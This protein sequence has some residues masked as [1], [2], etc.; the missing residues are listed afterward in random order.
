MKINPINISIT[1]GLIIILSSVSCADD[2]ILENTATNGDPV[3]FAAKVASGAQIETRA[4]NSSY[5]Y[6]ITAGL[7][8]YSG[9]D[10]FMQ[11]LGKDKTGTP[12]SDIGTYWV[13]SGSSG[14]LS[15][16]LGEKSLNWVYR[17]SE[18]YFRGWTLP[19]MQDEYDYSTDP[20]VINFKDTPINEYLS[21]VPGSS[22]S[23]GYINWKDNSWKNGE[24]LEKFVGAVQGPLTYIN[25]GEFV[26]IQ[27]RHLVSK[28][29]LNNFAI[30]DNANAT[31]YTN[32]KGNITI[33]G[34]PKTAT[35]YP[36]PLNEDG[37]PAQPYVAMPD[38]FNYPQDEGVTFA[39]TNI[40]HYYHWESSSYTYGQYKDCWYI[41]PEVDLSK[42]SFKIEIYESYKEG[43]GENAEIK[44]RLSP[45]HGNHGAYY[46]DFKSI[47]L[48]RNGTDYDDIPT[49]TDK[50]T[51]HAGEYLS[52][53]MNLYEKGN[54]SVKG[55]IRSW[56]STSRTASQH[57]QP[58][59]YS[60]TE[61]REMSDAM[62]SKNPDRIQEYWDLYGSGENTN[63]NPDDPNYG[64]DLDIFYL[65]EDIGSSG[66][67]TSSYTKMSSYYV[68]DG[69]ILDGKGHTI[70]VTGT[71][72]SIGHMRDVYL[73]YYYSSTTNGVTTTT[74]YI[75]YIR[76]DGQVCL[77]DTTG[78]TYQEIP[79]QYNVNDMTKNPFTI[80][81]QTGR[82]S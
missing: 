15:P 35:F 71:S 53:S 14:T 78:G 9:I 11:V 13:P 62:N 5:V 30:I 39:I 7:G 56:G 67:G 17:N 76:P 3:N 29:F 57:V 65:Y 66:S 4:R 23:R 41:C 59:V 54:P 64:D 21:T 2:K 51:L 55:T 43:E 75:V 50:T 12:K 36:N 18:H 26:T 74:E 19:W 38:D 70:N 47:S 27:F 58:G 10:F 80:N 44:W 33:Y 31:S 52:L 20:I 22:S 82:L 16:K 37:S 1:A 61:A 77:V 40:S 6:N 8:G 45:S 68:A 28:I 24:D 73:R 79:T 46:G 48:T 72:I 42:L 32:L 81:F 69:Y 34:L 25:N 63:D 60:Y 49:G